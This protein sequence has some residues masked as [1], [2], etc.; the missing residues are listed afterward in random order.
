MTWLQRR[1]IRKNQC[2]FTY[3]PKT[4]TP[5]VSWKLNKYFKS[6]KGKLSSEKSIVSKSKPTEEIATA[7]NIRS[8]ANK[9]SGLELF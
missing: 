4:K 2:S 8:V 3:I 6:S 7:Q 5:G 1:K 9:F